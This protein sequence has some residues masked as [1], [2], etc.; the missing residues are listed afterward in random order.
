MKVNNKDMLAYYDE[1]RMDQFI[2]DFL[3]P[4]YVADFKNEDTA[5]KQ[6]AKDYFNEEC[7]YSDFVDYCCEQIGASTERN[8]CAVAMS[9][10]KLNNMTL[11]EL[12]TK[13]QG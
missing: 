9:L 7:V 10:A 2:E 8:V 5:C 4:E 12:F 1:E 11:G 6:L 13:Y 3:E